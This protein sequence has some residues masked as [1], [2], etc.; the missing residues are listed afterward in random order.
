MD[1]TTILPLLLNASL[2][3]FER[4]RC[5][6]QGVQNNFIGTVFNLSYSP[7]IESC[8]VLLGGPPNDILSMSINIKFLIKVKF[9]NDL[10]TAAHDSSV[11]RQKVLLIF[12][13]VT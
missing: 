6:M 2:I 7:N 1:E 10:L 12:Y 11:L 3:W 8:R 5:S 4:N 13:K 9:A